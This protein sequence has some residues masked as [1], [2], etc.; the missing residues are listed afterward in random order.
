MNRDKEGYFKELDG[1]K[2]LEME[3]TDEGANIY[4]D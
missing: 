4:F 2:I 1:Q 3:S